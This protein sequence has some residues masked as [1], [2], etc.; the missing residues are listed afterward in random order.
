MSTDETGDRKLVSDL[1]RDAK[2]MIAGERQAAEQLDMLEPLTPEEMLEAREALG[3][4]AGGLAVVH[5]A[6]ENRKG[7]PPGARNR[8]TDDFARYILSFGQHP[9]ITMMQIQSTPAE[10]LIARSR[11]KVMKVLKGGKDRDDLIVEVEED[12]LTYEGAESLRLRAAEGLLPF[13]ESK[14]I[15]V[16]ATLRTDFTL[17]EEVND[18]NGRRADVEDGDYLEIQ[19][20]PPEEDDA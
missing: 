13:I 5:K 7:R 19:P 18:P 17:I 12:T 6:R 14:K 20:E 16:D 3:P 10:L 9:A 11:R 8:R 2:E 1:V 15:A 4:N